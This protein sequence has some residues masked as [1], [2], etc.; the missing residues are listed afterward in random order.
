MLK[1]VWRA[2]TLL[3]CNVT[4]APMSRRR[5]GGA[6]SWLWQI[7]LAGIITYKT[8]TRWHFKFAKL[9]SINTKWW[10]REAWNCQSYSINFYFKLVS[11]LNYQ[12]FSSKYGGRKMSEKHWYILTEYHLLWDKH[13]IYQIFL[14]KVTLHWQ[15]QCFCL[16][17]YVAYKS[18]PKRIRVFFTTCLNGIFQVINETLICSNNQD[19]WC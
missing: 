16:G 12:N 18:R 2:A 13:R 11:F 10:M 6:P 9:Y 15:G 17:S 3:L 4:P 14:T 5:G 19:W 8:H 7:N 1:P